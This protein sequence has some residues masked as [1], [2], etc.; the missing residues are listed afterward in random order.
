MEELARWRGLFPISRFGFDPREM[1]YFVE[2]L[3]QQAWCDFP[4][5]EVTQSPVMISQPMKELE[6][7]I[8][9][10][11]MCHSGDP[12]LAWMMGNVVQ[13]S[14]NTGSQTKYYFPARPND[15]SKIDGA[16]AL[17]MALDGALRSPAPVGEA[18]V[19]FL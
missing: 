6:A 17:I 16:A 1:S 13:K 3:Q 11:L 9:S 10:G 12:V 2:Q 14:T 19:F 15:H 8:N 4:I 18:G 7:L 5:V